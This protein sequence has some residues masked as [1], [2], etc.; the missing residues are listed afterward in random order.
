[1]STFTAIEVDKLPAPDI[2]EQRTFEAIY[3]ERLAEFRRLCPEYT[4]VV[5]SDPVVKILQASAYRE[6]LLR[7]QFN[8]RARGLLLP[9]SQGGDLDNLAVPYGVQRKLI[10]PADPD[11]G[12]PAVYESDADFRRRIQLAPEGLSV[13]GPEGA[14]IFHTL[15]A[16]VAVLDASVDSP[17]PGEVVVT[18]LSREGD[19]TPSAQLLATVESALL[20]GNVRPLTDHVRVTAA[21]VVPYEIRAKLTTFNGPDSALVLAEAQRRVRLFLSQSQRLGR[22]VPLSALYSALHVEGVKKVLLES[23]A[24]E[25]S[26]N[27]QQAAFCTSVVIDHVG[28]DD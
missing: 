22:D 7:E 15:S 13:A 4:A 5:E 20:N 12:T 25:L 19:G 17:S 10:T 28:S 9:Y 18:V 3:A 24:S 1:M 21:M 27:A 8:Q 2:F 11:A 6:V 23:P 14:Y 16:Q 26:L